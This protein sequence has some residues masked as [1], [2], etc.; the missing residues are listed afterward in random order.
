MYYLVPPRQLSTQLTISRAGGR[1]AALPHQAKV[2]LTDQSSG[3]LDLH[4]L[5]RRGT[6]FN[7]TSR[8]DQSYVDLGPASLF[9]YHFTIH[10]R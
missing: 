2:Q 9:K 1:S 5:R 3:E 8:I 4:D 10:G 6:K 7:V